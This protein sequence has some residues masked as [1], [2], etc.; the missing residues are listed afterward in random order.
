[1][2]VEIGLLLMCGLSY[3]AGITRGLV[4]ERERQ[5]DACFICRRFRGWRRAE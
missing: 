4:T 5:K 1:M 2:I 3:W